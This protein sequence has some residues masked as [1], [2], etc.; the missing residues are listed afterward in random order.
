MRIRS[1]NPAAC[2]FTFSLAEMEHVAQYKLE[3]RATLLS[4]LPRPLFLG[5]P[6]L[7]REWFRPVPVM[8]P[9]EFRR[10]QRGC[11]WLSDEAR[12]QMNRPPVPTPRK[13]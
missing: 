12:G 5:D 13:K 9:E 10:Q 7:V 6:S 1:E 4:E 2:G 8:T 11:E 3:V